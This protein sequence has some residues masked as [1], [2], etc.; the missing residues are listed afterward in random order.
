[1]WHSGKTPSWSS[2][3]Q[4]FVSSLKR[5]NAKKQILEIIIPSLDYIFSHRVLISIQLVKTHVHFQSFFTK[6]LVTPKQGIQYCTLMVTLG[7]ATQIGMIPVRYLHW[8][9][10]L[11][12]MSAISNSN[13]TTFAWLD[14]LGWCSK[15]RNISI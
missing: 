1:M 13:Y 8:K 4:G 14:F 6:M 10:L 7:D 15:N 3:G 9:S 5:E 12:K 2:Y 11:A